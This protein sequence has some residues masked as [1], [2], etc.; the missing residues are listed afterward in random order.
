MRAPSVCYYSHR[1]PP[2]SWAHS[3]EQS[4]FILIEIM[5]V[6][7]IIGILLAIIYQT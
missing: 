3:S 2:L 6:M 7:T 4:G 1:K 5:I